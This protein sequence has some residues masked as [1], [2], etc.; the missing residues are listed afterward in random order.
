MKL[1]VVKYSIDELV[2]QLNQNYI[3]DR[4]DLKEDKLFFLLK[5]DLNRTQLML[6]ISTKD[7][8]F[9]Y[10]WRT[11]EDV[12]KLNEFIEKDWYVV[13]V[14]EHKD[15]FLYLIEKQTLKQKR[16]EKLEKIENEVNK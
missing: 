7:N 9:E 1:L 5:K 13:E 8:N 2:K 10:A 3:V 11:P 6:S 12:R 16:K 14:Y 15:K 4:V